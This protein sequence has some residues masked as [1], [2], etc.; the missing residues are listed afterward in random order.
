MNIQEALRRSLIGFVIVAVCWLSLSV[1]AAQAGN[2]RLSAAVNLSTGPSVAADEQ[3][4]DGRD[5]AQSAEKKFAAY[6]PYLQQPGDLDPPPR[7]DV[8]TERMRALLNDERVAAGCAP[9]TVN[10]ELLRA[11]QTHTKDMADHGFVDHRGT[12]GTMPHERVL[13]EGYVYAYVGESVARTVDDA[14]HVLSLWMNSPGHRAILL[15]CSAQEMGLGHLASYWTLVL[16][17]PM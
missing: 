9:V 13:R 12:D 6:L 16:A 2:Q 14:E 5:D 1:S 17:K 15:N 11:A 8:V 4:A 7:Y 10:D 3:A